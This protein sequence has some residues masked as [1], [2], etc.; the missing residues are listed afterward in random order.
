MGRTY[1]RRP[2]FAPGESLVLKRGTACAVQASRP[3]CVRGKLGTP[4]HAEL[5]VDASQVEL[6]RLGGEEQSGGGLPVARPSGHDQR[7]LK[8]VGGE[9][10]TV[11]VVV[12]ARGRRSGR[13]KFAFGARGP[14]P[15]SEEV[16]RL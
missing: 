5:A 9:L 15:G 2:P 12:P 3:G 8:L 14:G 7:D 10:V 1:L 6:D 11:A 16:K 13:A 4:A